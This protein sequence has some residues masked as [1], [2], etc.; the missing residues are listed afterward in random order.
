MESD[1]HWE[2]G[3]A[4][5]T[6]VNDLTFAFAKFVSLTLWPILVSAN[7]RIFD[8]IIDKSRKIDSHCCNTITTTQIMIINIK[9]YKDIKTCGWW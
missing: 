8:D 3:F 5:R 4:N 1:D 9:V 6:N 7:K 2:I